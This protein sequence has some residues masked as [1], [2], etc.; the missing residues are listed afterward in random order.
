MCSVC[1]INVFDLSV[2]SESESDYTAI[3]VLLFLRKL[4]EAYEDGIYKEYVRKRYNEYDFKG[5]MDINR[6]IKINNPFLGKTAY[7]TREYSYDNDILCLIRQTLDYIKDYF[8]DI[9]KGYLNNNVILNEI[10]DAIENA[11]PSYRM[12]VNYSD[13]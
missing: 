10:I 7:S 13:S 4:M 9:L 2:N 11:T 5:V 6:H 12:N 3:M 8:P 1:G